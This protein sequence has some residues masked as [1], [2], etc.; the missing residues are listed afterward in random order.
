MSA[1]GGSEAGVEAFG[2]AGTEAEE[3]AVARAGTEAVVG[4]DVGEGVLKLDNRLNADC[5]ACDCDVAACP[6]SLC[7]FSSGRKQTTS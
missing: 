5:D 4:A 1:A 7:P 3:V 2:Q 6:L